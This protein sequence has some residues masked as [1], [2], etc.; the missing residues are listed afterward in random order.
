[1]RWFLFALTLLLSACVGSNAQQPA[2]PPTGMF[3][4][5]PDLYE[6]VQPS[7]VAMFAGLAEGSG[8]VWDSDGIIVTNNHVVSGTRQVEVAFATG[9]RLPGMVRASDPRTDL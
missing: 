5:I 8:V 2:A 7:V 9:E 6:E 1:M 3:A 4:D